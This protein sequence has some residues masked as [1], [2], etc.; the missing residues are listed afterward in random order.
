[1]ATVALAVGFVVLAGRWDP[2]PAAGGQA[3]VPDGRALFLTGCAN[4][5]GDDGRGTDRGPSLEHAG[6]ASAYYY[7]ETGRM[8]MTDTD[9]QPR[10]K[11]PAYEPEERDALVEYVGTLGDGV[12]LGDVVVDADDGDVA[13]GGTIYRANCAPC[14]S[15]AGIGGAL[16]QGRLAPSVDE[17]SPDVVA[18][19]VRVGPGQMPVFPPEGLDDQDLADV[20]AYTQHLRDRPNRGG[21]ALG[22]AGPIPEGAVAWL[23]GFGVMAA[24]TWWIGSRERTA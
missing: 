11:P 5:H 9:G 13:S 10:R 15:A 21:A 3:T 23:F 2:D 22:G 8:P 19:A 6:T 16:N 4:C 20:I 1:V 14:H 18:A 7:L 24:A 17:A 12:D